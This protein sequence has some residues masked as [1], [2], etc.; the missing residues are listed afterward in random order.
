MNDPFFELF[1]P[2]RPHPGGRGHLRPSGRNGEAGTPGR[3]IEPIQHR[4]LGLEAEAVAA[5]L[6][7]LAGREQDLSQDSMGS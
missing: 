1:E 7:A 3:A 6:A 5:L 4:V 2:D